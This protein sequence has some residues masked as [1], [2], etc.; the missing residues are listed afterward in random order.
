MKQ[1]NIDEDISNILLTKGLDAYVKINHLYLQNK[2]TLYSVVLGQCME[3]TNYFLE[4]EGSSDDIKKESDVIKILEVIMSISYMYE[5]KSYPF[6]AV[7]KSMKTFYFS[8][9]QNK[10]ACD[11]YL[12][13]MAN[14]QD[15]MVH[16]R[17]TL[18]TTHSWSTIKSKTQE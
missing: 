17:R 8:Y 14:M 16:Y 9:Q 6:L 3:Y 10:I 1:E 4:G 11:S 7:H 13:S 5:S 18:E 2:V 15:I 12:E